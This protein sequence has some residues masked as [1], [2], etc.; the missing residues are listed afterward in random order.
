MR[1]G[2]NL[3]AGLASS[4][5][6]AIVGL[7]VI[8]LYLKHLGIDAYGLIG[9]FATTQA[10]LSLLDLGL[11]PTINREVARRSASGN[12]SEARNLL[13]TLSV[14][15][16]V[17]AFIVFSIVIVL[18]PYVATYWLR[19]NV[20]GKESLE[21]ALILMG[22]VVACRWPIGL[23]A[24]ALMGM[25][26][27]VI[28]STISAAMMTFGSI[29][30]VFILA[31]ISPTIEAF[32]IWQAGV[33]LFHVAVIRSNAWKALGK[34]EVG[35]FDI[36]ELKQIWRFSVGVSGITLSGIVLMQLD[37]ILLSKMLSLDDFGRYTLAGAV[38]SALYLFITPLFNAIYPRMS[39]L[40]ATGEIEKLTS[41]Y[42]IGT[43]FFLALFFPISIVIAVFSENL[44]YLWTRNQQ[45]AIS[46]APIV[47]LFVIGTALNGVMHFP[48]ALQLASG[49]TKLP[50]TINAILI[51]IMIPATIIF[52]SAYG[53]LGG[54]A[55]WA[56]L[57]IIYVVLG[58][59]LTHRTILKEIG[60]AW[61]FGDVLFPLCIAGIIVGIGGE[62]IRKG[63]HGYYSFLPISM[64]LAFIAS[65][66]IITWSN[67]LRI[68]I[69]TFSKTFNRSFHSRHK[70]L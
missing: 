36:N 52:A 57:N 18:A 19:S 31:F 53:A 25:Q 16:W 70:N 21:H 28:S 58:T 2:Q 50:L 35:R 54:A 11:A 56:L 30:A 12:L 64:G 29:G 24:G 27:V 33:A 38:A 6:I 49:A 63:L 61:L 4:I 55:A 40:V 20:I 44:L 43:R 22:L 1:L 23:Y 65:S 51:A 5:W 68:A 26:R 17:M 34:G 66:L 48:Y 13:H 37:K 32:F 59:W 47:S 67:D 46:S 14:V 8:P 7:A 39:T 9:F 42:R 41:L 62:L 15:Y 3:L 69:R 60:K 10:L 45:L